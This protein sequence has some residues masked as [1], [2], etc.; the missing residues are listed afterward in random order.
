MSTLHAFIGELGVLQKKHGVLICSFE[1][2]DGLETMKSKVEW[3]KR[4]AFEE[5]KEKEFERVKSKSR[6]VV[7]FEDL[8]K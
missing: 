3:S 6:K 7:K 1:I 2:T 8:D 4:R 5:M